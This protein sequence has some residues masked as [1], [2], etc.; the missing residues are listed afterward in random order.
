MA[1]KPTKPTK[2]TKPR[3][4]LLTTFFRDG[5]RAIE[6]DELDSPKFRRMVRR[7]RND[8]YE[9]SMADAMEAERTAD[10]SR[11]KRRGLSDLTALQ[12]R[13]LLDFYTK[14]GGYNAQTN[15]DVKRYMLRNM[16]PRTAGF[17]G[18]AKGGKVKKMAKGGSTASKRG[19][20]CATKGKTKGRFV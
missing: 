3:S 10:V 4:E 2:S 9:R 7:L 6:R 5:D 19:D 14:P 18:N 20:G 16:L 17:G 8:P 11:A 13:D 1:K 12:D 15:E